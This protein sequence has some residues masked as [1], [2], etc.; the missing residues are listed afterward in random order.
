MVERF[1]FG[2]NGDTE[3]LRY[4]M[5]RLKEA[6]AKVTV[7]TTLETRHEFILHTVA[8]EFPKKV[9]PIV[10]TRACDYVGL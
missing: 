6:G 9:N 4:T 7:E 8:A 10:F 3:M 1:T 5:A 2:G